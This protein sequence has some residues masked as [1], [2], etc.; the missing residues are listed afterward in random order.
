MPSEFGKKFSLKRGDIKTKVKG[1][2]A[3][4]VWKDKGNVN[5]LTNM[6]RPPAESN[7][8]DEYVNTLK[9]TIVQDCN[10]HGVRR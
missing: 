1:D 5:M 6:H 4:V 9:P 10:T 7:F 2:L 3:S 8:C